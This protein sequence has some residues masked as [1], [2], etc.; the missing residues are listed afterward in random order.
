MAVFDRRDERVEQAFRPAACCIVGRAALAA[1]VRP[2]RAEALLHPV[3]LRDLLELSPS[4]PEWSPQTAV[5][6]RCK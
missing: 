5:P 2:S 3:P 6:C 1:E 4:A